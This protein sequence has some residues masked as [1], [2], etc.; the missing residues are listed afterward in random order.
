MPEPKAK[1]QLSLGE[2]VD[3][4][5][6]SAEEIREAERKLYGFDKQFQDYPHP[7]E[8]PNIKRR[9][10]RDLEAAQE[11]YEIT[12]NKLDKRENKYLDKK[13]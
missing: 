8:I 2:L 10:Q 12:K 5:I 9:Y 13:R 1:M 7:E 4:M 3:T 11:R 6:R